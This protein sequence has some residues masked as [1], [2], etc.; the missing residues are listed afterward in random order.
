MAVASILYSIRPAFNS[1]TVRRCQKSPCRTLGLGIKPFGTERFGQFGQIAHGVGVATKTSKSIQPFE[2]FSMTSASPA[3]SAPAVWASFTFSPFATTTT[4]FSIFPFH[5]EETRFHERSGSLFWHQRPIER[6]FP[7]FH[8]IL[9]WRFVS[10]GQRLRRWNSVFRLQLFFEVL[11]I[12]RLM[13]DLFLPRARVGHIASSGLP[14][15]TKK[16]RSE[17]MGSRGT[18]F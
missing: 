3:S 4:L 16:R 5:G 6:E 15:L 9:L 11:G 2:I 14:P 1:L 18:K 17:V 10:P 13:G 12:R 7:R 8:Q